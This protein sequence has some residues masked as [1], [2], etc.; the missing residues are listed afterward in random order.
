MPGEGQA[1]PGSSGLPA[2]GV[3]SA[4]PRRTAWSRLPFYREHSLWAMGLFLVFVVAR[5]M[6]W[7]DRRAIFAALRIEFVLGLLT[8]A[9]TIFLLMS[10][11]V[12]LRPA[13]RVL[14]AIG[15]LFGA[16]VVQLPFAADPVTANSIFMDRVL[17]FAMMTF[18]MVVL[19]QS[20]RFMWFFLAAL[21]LSCFY[22]TQESVRGLIS[23]SLVWQN[24]GVMRLHGAVSIYRHPNSLG[25]VAMGV[26][27]F[28]VFLFPLVRKRYLRA[29]LLGLLATSLTC[30]LY[31]GSRTAYVAFLAFAFFWWLMSANKLKWLGVAVVIGAITLAVIPEQYKERFESIGG[32]EAEGRSKDKRIEI[33]EDAVVVFAE[34]PLGVG[35]ASFPAVRMARFGRSQDTHNLYLEVGTNLGIQGL[36]VFLVLVF[37]LMKSYHVARGHF[38]RQRRELARAVAGASL[39]GPV[40]R[41]LRQQAR[42][43]DFLAALSVACSGFIF[44]R[45]VLGLFGMDL[46]E[47]YWWF[48]AGMAITLLNL[49]GTTGANTRRLLEQIAEPA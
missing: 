35:I 19:I 13:K 22:I 23:G 1:L 46:Y 44:V 43:L 26:V 17:K 18:F 12:N 16:M 21:L 14:I 3:D 41:S 37:Y 7:G 33:L 45:L 24:Q 15:A 47:V 31:S 4:A 8:L 38:R 28:V 30:V 29:F 11:P 20:P 6:Q 10:Q 2:G 27:P 34:H 25:G 49:T 40:R 9:V 48:G 5:Y 39:P 32:Q 42:D 36:V